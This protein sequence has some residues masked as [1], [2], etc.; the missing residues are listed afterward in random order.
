V[1]SEQ[2]TVVARVVGS[3]A[4]VLVALAALGVST[5]VALREPVPAWELDLTEWI[6]GVNDAVGTVTYPVMQM[7]TL[8]GPLL[9]AAGIVVFRRDWWLG[10]SAAFA[11]LLAWFGAKGVKRLVERSRPIDFLPDII[12]REGDGTGLGF[13]SG[14]SAVAATA[15]VFA[16]VALP[17]RWRF[18]PPTVAGLVGMARIVHGVHLPADV[19]GGWSFGVLIA[20][21]VLALLDVVHPQHAAAPPLARASR[22]GSIGNG[23]HTRP[24]L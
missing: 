15:A 6:N 12:V 24:D 18:A 14:H 3:P 23:S 17:H 21:G 13:V 16:M 4:I 8:A 19:V 7:G 5:V 2:P 11:G 22:S 10:G 1:T 20:S 9:V